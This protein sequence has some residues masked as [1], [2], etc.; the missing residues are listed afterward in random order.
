[1]APMGSSKGKGKASAKMPTSV[2]NQ[3]LSLDQDCRKGFILQHLRGLIRICKVCG[4]NDER[5]CDICY[6]II[7]LDPVTTSHFS[8]FLLMWL[9]H[10]IMSSPFLEMWAAF[11]LY[12][13]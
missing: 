9:H 3:C 12:I 8:Q 13:V 4:V 7:I 6:N 1:M 10:R 11:Y 5:A 2:I